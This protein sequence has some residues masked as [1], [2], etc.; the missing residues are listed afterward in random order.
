MNA[1]IEVG[2][3]VALAGQVSIGLT[4][5]D[6]QPERAAAALHVIGLM[7]LNANEDEFVRATLA[8]SERTTITRTDAGWL[9]RPEPER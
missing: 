5:G 9:I 6:G 8:M 1:A 4:P 3:A 7:L 2:L